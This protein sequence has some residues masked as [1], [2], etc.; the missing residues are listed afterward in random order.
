MPVHNTTRHIEMLLLL[1]PVLVLLLVVLLLLLLM[2]LMV[3]L[4]VQLQLVGQAPLQLLN[5][6]L[7]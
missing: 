3:E 2:L 6:W 7:D 5:I 1:L 4:L